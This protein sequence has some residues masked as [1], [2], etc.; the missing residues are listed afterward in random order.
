MLDGASVAVGSS[1]AVG[2]SVAVGSSVAVGT[3]VAVGSSVAVGTSVAVGVSKSG[4]NTSFAKA[5]LPLTVILISEF[6][7]TSVLPAT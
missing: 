1:V 7:V 3:S 6:A 2:T 5:T 4:V